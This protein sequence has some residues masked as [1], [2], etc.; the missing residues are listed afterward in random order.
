VIATMGSSIDFR[1]RLNEVVLDNNEHRWLFLEMRRS[2][3]QQMHVLDHQKCTYTNRRDRG[4]VVII[5]AAISVWKTNTSARNLKDR[6][7]NKI[8]S[9]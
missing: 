4:K 8:V 1:K 6:Y 7:R 5:V 3:R 9:L 2:R